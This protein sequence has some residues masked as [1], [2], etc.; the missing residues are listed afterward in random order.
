MLN[1]LLALETSTIIFFQNLLNR[2][3]KRMKGKVVPINKQAYE[4]MYDDDEIM[5][6]LRGN[7]KK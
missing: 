6:D 1:S 7:E 2:R 5:N 3:Y 4:K